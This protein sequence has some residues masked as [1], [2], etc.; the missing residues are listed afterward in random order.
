MDEC[1]PLEAGVDY[2][3]VTVA[4]K[5]GQ[6]AGEFDMPIAGDE[7]SCSVAGLMES[8]AYDV[9]VVSKDNVLDDLL[10]GAST[11]PL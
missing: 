6:T 8:T 7:Y 4:A 5:C 3:G 9:Y 11:R 1:K 2:G 10:A